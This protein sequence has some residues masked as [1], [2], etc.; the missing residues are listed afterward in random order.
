MNKEMT[1]YELQINGEKIGVYTKWGLEHVK[2]YESKLNSVIPSIYKD[3]A[4]FDDNNVIDL[5]IAKWDG[6]MLMKN[7]R[8]VKL[9]ERHGL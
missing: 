4:E 5:I 7:P 2:K 3:I 6:P 1:G 8:S 9:K